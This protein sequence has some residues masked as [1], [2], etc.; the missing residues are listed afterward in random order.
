MRLFLV[1]FLALPFPSLITAQDACPANVKAIPLHRLNQHQ[2][3]VGVSIN[4][5]RPYD[6]LIDTGTQMTVVDR[7]LADE[8]HLVKSGAANVAGVSVQGTASYAQL[9]SLEVGEHL[10]LNQN[11]V[12]YDMKSVQG[13]G[14][15]LRGLLGEDFLSRYD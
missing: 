4:H 7:T 13:A 10:A 1:L 3:V 6:F 14:F 15:A 12:V 11:V 2:M 8:L 5:S 9:A